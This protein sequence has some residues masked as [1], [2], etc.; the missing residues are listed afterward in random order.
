[1]ARLRYLQSAKA[2]ILSILDYVEQQAGWRSAENLVSAL[3]QRCR[4]LANL[5]GHM[6]RPRPELGK[7]IRSATLGNY[8]IFFRYVGDVL[9]VIDIL[10]GHR[11]IDHFFLGE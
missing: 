2:D 5:P 8:V 10:E 1:M 9:E 6:G 7:D 3:R 4:D 11:D